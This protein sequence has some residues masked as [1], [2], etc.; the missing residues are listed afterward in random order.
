MV[1]KMVDDRAVIKWKRE[2]M[3]LSQH[4]LAR[5]PGLTQ[6]FL[7]EMERGRKNPSIEQSFRI[8]ETLN[9]QVFPDK[10]EQT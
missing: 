2:K 4:Q 1:M 10:E 6:I 9:I 3:G 8:C 5:Q 7:S